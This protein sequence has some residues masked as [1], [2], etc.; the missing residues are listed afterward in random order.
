VRI[1]ALIGVEARKRFA[2]FRVQHLQRLVVLL[3]VEHQLRQ[4]IAG[5]FLQFLFVG[6]VD[7]P[8]QLGPGRRGVSGIVLHFREQ[9]CRA[10][11]VA[12]A[13][14][15]AGELARCF[16]GLRDIVGARGLR[17]GVEQHRRLFGLPCGPP[18]PALHGGRGDARDHEHG[19]HGVAP[20]GPP[21]LQVVQLFLFFEIVD[22][23]VPSLVLI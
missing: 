7:H 4:A 5:N 1:T 22:C 8:L 19:G 15:L 11:R 12:G 21:R 14:V 23:H 20:A 9:E 13:A 3:V 18:A 10:W 16:P 2:V 6:T 17:Y